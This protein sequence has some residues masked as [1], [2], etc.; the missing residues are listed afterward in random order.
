[1]RNKKINKK[2]CS[3]K[4]LGAFFFFF[5]FFN[6]SLAFSNFFLG[7][8]NFFLAFFLFIKEGV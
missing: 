3:L 5:V 8:L 1:M 4:H 6:F 7:F 2:E